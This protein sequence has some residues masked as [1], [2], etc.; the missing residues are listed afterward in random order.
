MYILICFNKLIT[1]SLVFIKYYI[2]MESFAYTS[3]SHNIIINTFLGELEISMKKIIE[4]SKILAIYDQN[5]ELK[6]FSLEVEFE[7]N[8]VKFEILR[9]HI[10]LAF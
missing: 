10:C 3:N 4:I 1:E 5:L 8:K 7:F 2:T 9:K 6:D